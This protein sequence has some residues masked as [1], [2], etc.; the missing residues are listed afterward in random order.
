ML[1]VAERQLNAES[2][3]AITMNAVGEAAGVSRALVY[4]YFPD[5]YRLLDALLAR[6]VRALSEAGLERAA[7][8]GGAL[9]RLCACARL[10]LRHLLEYRLALEVV[11]REPDVARQ[12]DGAVSAFRA[13]IYRHLVRA[14]REELAM[15]AHEA[16]IFVQL[17]AV[18][19]AETAR[20]ALDGKLQPDEADELVERMVATSFNALL[21]N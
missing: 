7:A 11:M 14:V 15:T 2:S 3:A 10:Y 4:A 8:S 6:H 21:P 16:L 12:L 1:D 13:R 19:P 17:L 9:E 18:I 5:Q 20:L